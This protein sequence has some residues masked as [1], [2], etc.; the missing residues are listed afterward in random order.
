MNHINR[1][2][3]LAYQSML[4]SMLGVALLLTACGGGGGSPEPDPESS[5][6]TPTPTMPSPT[7]TV[8]G[9]PSTGTPPAATGT[10]PVGLQDSAIYSRPSEGGNDA[11]R[12]AIDA[13]GNAISLWRRQVTS[14]PNT[15]ELLA[16][17]YVV[18]SGW[19]AIE[20]LAADNP[21]DNEREIQEPIQLTIHPTTGAAMAVWVEQR[22]TGNGSGLL[23]SFVRA[24]AYDPVSGWGPVSMI[25]SD[26]PMIRFNVSL[27]TDASGNVMAVWSRYESLQ[28]TIYASRYT[29]AGGW[30]AP[31][32]IE[33]ENTVGGG[34]G[35]ML[36]TFLPSGN[37]LVVWNS[38]RGGT[39][40]N[41]WGNQYTV[42]SG[43]GTNAL[44]MSGS[45][46]ATSGLIRL[47]GGVRG[48]AADQNG[49]AVLT[50][51]NQQLFSNPSRY[52]LNL[53]SKRYSGGAW[54]AD[55][56]AVP[57]GVPLTCSNCPS[58]YGG[59]VQMNPQGAAVATWELRNANGDSVI[60]AARSRSDGT[61]EPQQ[62]N[63]NL[64]GF[65]PS[66]EFP[67]AGIDDQGNVSVLWAYTT[68]ET[69]IYSARYT[70]GSGWAAPVLL[71]E[72]SGT[73]YRPSIAMNARGYAM[74]VWLLFESAVGTVA[75]SRYFSSGR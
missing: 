36:V 28:T 38:S 5:S 50:F 67:Q 40:S 26:A 44:V 56:T 7:I 46:A 64:P 61:W 60:W 59:S 6:P 33:D 69:N 73:T 57:V 71:E 70:A 13:T 55:S 53:W 58:V 49:N 48:L 52:E 45:G 72:Y 31:V 20:V 41:I 9:T 62:L 21:N 22:E 47:L 51:E 65:R 39:T 37:A 16:R 12:V 35:G 3:T 32:R 19:Q 63:A 17:R 54:G 42:G 1:S 74:T 43:W 14:L 18:G 2:K 30:T 4:A 68:S 8:P 23:T 34:G 10:V 15:Y 11:P 25:D 75:A 24:R 27:A 29:A 66:N